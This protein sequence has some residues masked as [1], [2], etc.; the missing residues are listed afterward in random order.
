MFPT[1]CA[2]LQ[3]PIHSNYRL[4]FIDIMI[5]VRLCPPIHQIL[6][7]VLIVSVF[8]QGGLADVRL[9]LYDFKHCF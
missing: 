8:G 1:L 4:Y 2:C 7:C 3:T 6:I 5:P 9:N